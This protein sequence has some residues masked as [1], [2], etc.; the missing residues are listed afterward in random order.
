MA[1]NELEVAVHMKQS[2]VSN[3]RTGG[4]QQIGNTHPS[5]FG[6]LQKGSLHIESSL[7]GPWAE[8]LQWHQ[9][10]RRFSELVM[11]LL[12]VLKRIGKLEHGDGADSDESS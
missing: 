8:I 6:D 11:C 5:M 12:G 1:G 7:F 3:F 4:D 2:V 9:C 10:Q